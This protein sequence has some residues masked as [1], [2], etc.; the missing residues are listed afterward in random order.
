MALNVLDDLGSAEPLDAFSR[1]KNGIGQGVTG[2]KRGF[3]ILKYHVA[4]LVLDPGDF[5]HDDVPFLVELDLRKR[6]TERNVCEQFQGSLCVLGPLRRRDPGVFLGG[7]CID[8]SAHGFHSIEDVERFALFCPFEQHVLNEVG[9]T[10]LSRTLIAC[11]CIDR[12]RTMRHFAG[13]PRM[14]DA[15]AVGQN[16][17]G[18][19][20]VHDTKFGW[21][22]IS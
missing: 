3:E 19:F 14:N 5:I 4:W 10:R 22:D 8:L 13:H 20:A 21:K 11:P 9:Q 12:K 1:A 16:M 2:K 15:Q 17:G 6:T 18:E 7:V